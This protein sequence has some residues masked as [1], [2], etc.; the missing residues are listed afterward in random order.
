MS[1]NQDYL[2]NHLQD[3]EEYNTDNTN[4]NGEDENQDHQIQSIRLPLQSRKRGAPLSFVWEYFDKNTVEY[5]V[6]PVCQICKALFAATTGT[7]TLRRHLDIHKI[8][9]PKKRQRTLYEYR[10]DPHPESEQQERDKFVAIWIVCDAQPFSI[11]E[12]EEW[13]QIIS[14]FDPRY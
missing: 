7:S 12:C 13:Q 1:D 14:K 9:V 5:P 10:T 2:P 3:D 8:I 4:F 11:V 6:R